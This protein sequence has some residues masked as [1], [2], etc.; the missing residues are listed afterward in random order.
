M[1]AFYHE[2]QAN[3]MMCVASGSTK[4]LTLHS[5]KQA[6][7]RADKLNACWFLLDN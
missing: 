5:L 2:E 1:N 6:T 4:A 3:M 7:Q